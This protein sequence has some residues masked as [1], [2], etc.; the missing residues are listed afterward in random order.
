MIAQL[1]RNLS[2]AR[3]LKL[4]IIAEVDRTSHG[5]AKSAVAPV[6]GHLDKMF[7]LMRNR[8]PG[9]LPSGPADATLAG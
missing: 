5:A 9:E 7:D 2:L 4:E 8:E 3:D 6:T 1:E